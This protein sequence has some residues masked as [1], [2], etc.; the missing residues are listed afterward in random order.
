MNADLKFQIS[1]LLICVHPRSSAV[2]YRLAF[3]P[4]AA[5]FALLAADLAASPW[6]CHV[7]SFPCR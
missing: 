4:I 2:H 1:D 6:L 7:A 3:A 5:G